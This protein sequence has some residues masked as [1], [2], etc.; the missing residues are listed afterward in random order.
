MLEKK[1]TYNN[2]CLNRIGYGKVDANGGLVS[3]LDIFLK[4]LMDWSSEH[5]P[6]TPVDG[7][8]VRDRE[9]IVATL[10]TEGW[11]KTGD[12]CYFDSDGLL[13]IVD[14]L[15]EPI[16]YKAYQIRPEDSRLLQW[17]A[18][19]KLKKPLECLMDILLLL[20][21]G[22][23]VLEVIEKAS[24]DRFVHRANGFKA[25]V[26]LHLSSV[27]GGDLW[28]PISF[29]DTTRGFAVIAMASIQEAKEAIRMFDGYV[30]NVAGEGSLECRLLHSLGSR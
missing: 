20:A 9:A 8:Y 5:R 1:I 11:L 15:K 24:V 2:F 12:L 6:M 22:I 28:V 26:R 16:K 27:P 3:K 7:C 13:Y 14:R 30:R 25:V 21:I 10:D 17:Q 4:L 19:K 29:S 23:G 18:F